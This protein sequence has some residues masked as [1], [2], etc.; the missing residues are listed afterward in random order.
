M[1]RHRHTHT[2]IHDGIPHSFYVSDVL[3]WYWLDWGCNRKHLPAVLCNGLNPK[4]Q[5]GKLSFPATQPPA[6]IPNKAECMFIKRYIHELI[7]TSLTQLR[8]SSR[9]CKLSSSRSRTFF[10][11]LS[12]LILDRLNDFT[13]QRENKMRGYKVCIKKK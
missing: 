1:G 13:L 10:F 2:Y 6:L 7:H 9:S 3:T 11:R 4:L 5:V 12:T 8:T